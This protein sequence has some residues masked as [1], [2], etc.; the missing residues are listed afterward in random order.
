[1]RRPLTLFFVSLLVGVPLAQA[2]PVGVIQ[3]VKFCGAYT[4][5]TYRDYRDHLGDAP[6]GSVEILHRDKRVYE[7]CGFAFFIGIRPDY[8]DVRPSHVSQDLTASGAPHVVIY[9]WTGGAHGNHIVHVF[10]LGRECQ[11]IAVINGEC[12]EPEFIEKKPNEAWEVRTRDSAFTYW[13][14]SYATSPF[15]EIVLRWA[16][17]H[18]VLAKDKMMKPAPSPRELEIWAEKIHAGPGWNWRPMAIP[19]ELYA[20]TLDLMYSGHE[21]L[22]WKFIRQGW[23]PAIPFDEK[24]VTGLKERLSES[25]YWAPLQQREPVVDGMK[26]S[27]K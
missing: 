2:D 10:R 20:I 24:L 25:H 22:G 21:D 8:P 7:P 15:P 5:R 9:E 18:Y 26:L 16:G 13:P 6:S 27:S 17:S 3:D 12:W 1:M 19:P 14:Q 11:E 23:N 4:I